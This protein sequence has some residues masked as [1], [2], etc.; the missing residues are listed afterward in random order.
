M[1]VQPVRLLVGE[2][3]ALDLDFRRRLY[4]LLLVDKTN[5]LSVFLR[6]VERDQG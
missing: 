3:F 6:V 4:V 1:T 5:V 2:F